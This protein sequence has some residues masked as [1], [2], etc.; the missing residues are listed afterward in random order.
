MNDYRNWSSGAEER[1]RKARRTAVIIIGVVFLLLIPFGLVV[2]VALQKYVDSFDFGLEGGTAADKY[3]MEEYLAYR[4]QEIEENRE[5]SANLGMGYD[6]VWAMTEESNTC[7]AK[8]D[9]KWGMVS[10]G[11]EV[12]I[13]FVY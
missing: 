2:S 11:G 5:L 9:G 7:I 12:L 4:M 10:V 13:P 6:G 3:V 8:K 1:E